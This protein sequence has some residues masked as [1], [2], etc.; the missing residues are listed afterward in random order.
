MEKKE[1]MELEELME[2]ARQTNSP[3]E[4]LALAKENNFPMNEENAK[5]YF[6]KLH[7]TGEL[8][9]DELDNVA[10]GGCGY[11]CP[12]CGSSLPDYR[13]TMFY[14]CPGCGMGVPNLT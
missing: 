3:E 12:Y 2:K 5:V 9:D 4:L 8:S 10:G 14:F 1:L 11:H 13:E 6:E 7:K